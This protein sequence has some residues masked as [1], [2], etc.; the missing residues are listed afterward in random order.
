MSLIVTPEFGY[1]LLTVIGMGFH[2]YI[3]GFAIGKLRKKLNVLYPDMGD[4]RHADKL[5]DEQWNL[6]A[7]TQRAH[8][9]YVEVLPMMISWTLVGGLKFPMI[10]T[11]FGLVSMVGR[12]L[13]ATGYRSGVAKNRMTGAIIGFLGYFGLLLTSVVSAL[14]FTELI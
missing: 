8:L 3:Q 6:F 11:G 13:Y 12:H 2:C 14:K 5:T 4:G 10:A 9:N 7:C 1:V